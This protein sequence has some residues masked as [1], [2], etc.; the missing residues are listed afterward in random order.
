MLQNLPLSAVR[1][2]R[3]SSSS[4]TPCIVMKNDGVLYRQVVV[5]SPEHWTEVVLQEHAVLGRVYRLPWRYSV[6]QY[7][8]INAIC[9]NEHHLHSTLCRAHFLWTRRIGNDSIY[10]NDISS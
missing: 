4:M 5:F 3:D 9:H 1:E 8:L 10:L 7:Y 2:I 6:V